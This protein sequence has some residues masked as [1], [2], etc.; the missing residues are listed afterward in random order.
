MTPPPDPVP[1][2][3]A[4][5][6]TL[7]AEWDRHQATWLAWPHNA[8]DWPAKFSPIPWIYAEI[9]RQVAASETVR[10][11]VNDAAHEARARRVLR[12]AGVELGSVELRQLP[13][14]RVW[15]RD[16][17]PLFVRRDGSRP[18]LGV[19]GVA[20]NAWAKYPNFDNDR[21]V[22]RAA[23]RAVG[24]EWLPAC[25]RGRRVVL[26]GGAIDTNGSGSLLT[27]EEC[28]LD[29]A[30]QVRN[31]GFDRGDYETIFRELFGI[32]NVIW[33]GR[34]ITGDDTH[35]HIDDIAR[36]V[37]PKTVVVATEPN[38]ADPNH[39]LLAECH[40]RLESARLEDGSRIEIVT[41]PMPAPVVV[42]GRRLPASYANFY[43]TNRAVLM[44]IFADPHDRHALGIL[45]ELFPDREVVGIYCRDLVWGLGTLHCLSQQ[46]PALAA[47]PASC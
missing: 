8:R 35:G 24:A 14:D 11:L 42:D 9:V 12:R 43:I 18:S 47:A 34:G 16:S 13:T 7:P 25:Y 46:E 39:Q 1:T 10:L 45:S 22:S 4:R 37:G 36:F 44:P 30:V 15:T 20:F 31:P 21:L 33:L 19:V 41:L 6:Y 26:E 3:A 28:L 38:P 5:G 32:S 2:A 23:A 17:G 27:T 40:E 29:P